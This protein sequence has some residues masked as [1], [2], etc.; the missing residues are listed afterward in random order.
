MILLLFQGYIFTHREVY[1]RISDLLPL[2]PGA[3][4]KDVQY[5]PLAVHLDTPGTENR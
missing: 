1:D 2:C 5:V 3:R 4:I